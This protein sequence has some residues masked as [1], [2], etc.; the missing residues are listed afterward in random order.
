[1][2]HRTETISIVSSNNEH[3]DYFASFSLCEFI[4]HS[5]SFKPWTV[6]QVPCHFCSGDS[7]FVTQPLFVWVW[8][9]RAFRPCVATYN[10]HL[11]IWPGYC[12]NRLML[13]C[14]MS[15]CPLWCFTPEVLSWSEGFLITPQVWILVC[16]R[17][18]LALTVWMSWGAWV[19]QQLRERAEKWWLFQVDL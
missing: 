13:W 4:I 8:P 16:T 6:S 2:S 5:W 12:N 7:H 10:P 17:L 15:G 14:G 3:I 9:W 11:E 1:M 19:G 18:G